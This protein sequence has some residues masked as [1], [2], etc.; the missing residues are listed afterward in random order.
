[1]DEFLLRLAKD[2]G[3]PALVA[4]YVLLRLDRRLAHVE[5]C[6]VRI[7]AILSATT[8]VRVEELDGPLVNEPSTPQPV[9]RGDGIAAVTG[10]GGTAPAGQLKKGG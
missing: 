8:G 5:H 10:D 4:A 2:F 1:M 3:F 9:P 7:C 6:L